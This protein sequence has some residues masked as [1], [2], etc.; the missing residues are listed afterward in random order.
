MNLSLRKP[1]H[2]LVPLTDSSFRPS[3]TFP[4]AEIDP[5][6]R[7]RQACCVFLQA[8]FNAARGGASNERLQQLSKAM[9][10]AK[11]DVLRQRPPGVPTGDPR[12]AIGT[13]K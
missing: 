10:K 12:P 6:A 4:E 9:W 5:E 7:Y 13:S 3:F 11:E 8:A 1:Y 2:R